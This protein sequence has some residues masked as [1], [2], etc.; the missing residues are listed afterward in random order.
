MRIGIDARELMG[1]RTGVGRYLADLCAQ[2]RRLPPHG[3]HRF[4]LYAPAPG[5]DPSVLGPP[6][7]AAAPPGRISPATVSV[8]AGPKT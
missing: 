2:W 8:A 6:F 7:D 3:P 5:S 4:L 1:R